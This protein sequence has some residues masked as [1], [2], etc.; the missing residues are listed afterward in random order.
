MGPVGHVL[1][2]SSVAGG[3][4]VATGS[5]A[6]AAVAVGVGVLTDLDHLYDY[7]QRHARRRRGKLYVLLHGWE[8]SLVG[9]GLLALGF[10][11]PI[12]LGRRSGPP[13]SRGG[14]RLAQQ[15]L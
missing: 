1:V 15:C 4:W 11:H 10:H 12:P 7:Y 2:S 3:V 5:T 13:G 6:A 9:L 14:R 8:Y